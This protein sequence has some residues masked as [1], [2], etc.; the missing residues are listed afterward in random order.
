MSSC[1]IVRTALPWLRHPPDGSIDLVQNLPGFA[2]SAP[3]PVWWGRFCQPETW[4]LPCWFPRIPG[5][6]PPV[7]EPRVLIHH[8]PIP[9]TR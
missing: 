8:A 6:R 7:R 9:P 2:D 5:T 4:Q 3:L 1:L